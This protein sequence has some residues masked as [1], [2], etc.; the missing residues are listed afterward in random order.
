[1]DER[2]VVIVGGGIAGLSAG[3]HA[4]RS[5]FRTTILEHNLALGGVCTAWQRGPYLVDGCIHWLTGGPFAALYEELG[6][7]PAVPLRTLETWLTYEDRRTGTSVAVSRDLD[8]LVEDLRPLG[9]EDALELERLRDG[10][11]AM[12]ALA[13]P[14]D[15]PETSACAEPAPALGDAG[16][17][18]FV[19]F[20]KTVGGWART[21]SEPAPAP[22]LGAHVEV[23]WLL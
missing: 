5:G 20:R 12:V 17:R 1:M 10:A 18:T 13:P 4:L 22:L 23:R 11:R 14:I 16:A 7:T 8:T 9:P 6:I 15:A 19:H 21:P 2:R 3:C